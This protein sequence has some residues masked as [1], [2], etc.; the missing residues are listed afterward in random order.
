[1]MSKESVYDAL[2]DLDTDVCVQMIISGDVDGLIYGY[3]H[4][5]LITYKHYYDSVK[6]SNGLCAGNVSK[7]WNVL[8]SLNKSESYIHINYYSMQHYMEI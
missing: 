6:E 4:N 1:M 5:Y 8:N 7:I 3:R 2:Y